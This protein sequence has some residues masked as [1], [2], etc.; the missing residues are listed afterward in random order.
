MKF[1]KKSRKID[2]RLEEEKSR[3]RLQLKNKDTKMADE[4]H[5]PKPRL[6][7]TEKFGRFSPLSAVIILW[8]EKK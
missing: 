1:I 6:I 2:S 3:N 4:F 5:F 8:K 7:L